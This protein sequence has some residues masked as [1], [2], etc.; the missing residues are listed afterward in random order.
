MA[1]RG[2]V[3]FGD[4]IVAGAPAVARSRPTSCAATSERFKYILVDEFQDTNYAQFE[5]VQLLAARHRNLTVV[6]DD[7]QSIYKWRGAAISNVLGFQRALPGRPRSRAD[8]ELPLAPGGARRRLPADP[9]TTIPDR[10]EVAVRH[11]QAADARGARARRTATPST[12]PS[13]R[14]PGGRR[15]RRR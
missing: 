9:A 7:D 5:L 8:R 2:Q 6:A 13:T 11:Q 3:D 1:R 4:Q 14:R 15:G 12:S 10:L